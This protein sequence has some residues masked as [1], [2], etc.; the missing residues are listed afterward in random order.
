VLHGA[1]VYPRSQCRFGAPP[2]MSPPKR[3]CAAPETFAFFL[4]PSSEEEVAAMAPYMRILH[5]Q[6]AQHPRR[7]LDPQHACVFIP[8]IDTLCVSNNCVE[9]DGLLSAALADL[10]YWN[11]NGANH[12]VFNFRD[13]QVST[14]HPCVRCAQLR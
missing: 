2:C 1:Q 3:H 11:G 9:T 8:N 13:M 7:T 14:T 10:Q 6:L 5:T 12:L 4:Y